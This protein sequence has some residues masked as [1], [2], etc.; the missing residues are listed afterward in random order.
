[1]ATIVNVAR[2][3]G[4]SVATV[5]HVLNQTRFVSKQL[6]RRVLQAAEALNYEPNVLAR[7]LRSRQTRAIGLILP[8][9]A[10]PFFAEVTKAVEAEC[11]VLG[12]Q[13]FVCQSDEALDKEHAFVSLLQSR[14]V[15]GLLLIPSAGDHTFLK[16]LLRKPLPIVF[17]SRYIRTLPIPAVVTDN[18]TGAVL[19][20]SHLIEAGRRRI[21]AVLTRKG[22]SVTADRL[23]GYRKALKTAG[24]RLE[25]RWV[26]EGAL[27]FDSAVEAVA[28]L[29]RLKRPPDA[30]FAFGSMQT[31]AALATFLN[32]G[33][34]CP[35]E[36]ALVGFSEHQW[37]AVTNPPVTCIA[38]PTRM[39]AATAVQLLMEA[40]RRRQPLSPEIHKLPP[41]LI[42]RRSCGCQ[43]A[44][45]D[46]RR[47]EITASG[48]SVARMAG[49]LLQR[50]RP[51]RSQITGDLR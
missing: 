16:P 32:L 13:V 20:V 42:D 33:Q 45:M 11:A 34:P 29:L 7:G 36:V 50:A 39:I 22:L 10:N 18:E 41:T 1:M 47:T 2:Q 5:S 44:S 43:R 51:S 48:G 4:V 46:V 15:D 35:E 26:V 49:D 3:A 38:Q 12:Y 9:I 28:S 6:T 37:A 25:G 17:L 21:A 19:G 31:L 14:L 24:L 8:D 30:F 40:I 27:P 23:Q